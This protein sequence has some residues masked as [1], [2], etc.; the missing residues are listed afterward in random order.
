[1]EVISL[2]LDKTVLKNLDKSLKKHNYSTRTE[3]VREAI[4]D[5]LDSLSREELL[6]EF[7]KLKGSKK[8]KTSDE[9][10]KRIR[11]EVFAQALEHRENQKKQ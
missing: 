7:L 4:R 5:K 9:E 6:Q 8:T 1:M 11:E 2:K 3:F 10:L